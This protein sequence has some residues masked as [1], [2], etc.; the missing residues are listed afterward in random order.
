[1][2][3]HTCQNN[4]LTNVSTINIMKEEA[5]LIIFIQN[6]LPRKNGNHLINRIK[7]FHSFQLPN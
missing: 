2:L 5:T 4:Y 1:M 6:C 3:R 7:A